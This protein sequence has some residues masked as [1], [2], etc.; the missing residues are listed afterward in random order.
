M[1][2]N[3]VWATDG[4]PYQVP[5]GNPLRDPV[6]RLWHRRRRRH[7]LPVNSVPGQR[8]HSWGVRDWW[9]MDWMWSA[10]HLEDG[11]H[12]HGVNIGYRAF[13]RSVSV[14]SRI[15]TASSPSWKRW[16]AREAFGANGLPVNTTLS[17]D[18]GELTAD[19]EVRGQ[20]PVRLT[21]PDGRVSE[22]PRAWVSVTTAD[23]RTGVGWMEWNRNL[24]QHRRERGLPRPI[25]V[26]GVSGSGK[27]TVGSALA[28][29]LRV[30]FVDADGSAPAR[31]HRQDERR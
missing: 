30:P 19:V 21:A 22:F 1:T 31:Q 28:Q 18:P 6:H 5:G 7:Q 2:M 25:V 24:A 12:L 10:V 14:T 4:T 8:D 26:M 29:R 23:G 27:S 9:S 20:A 17:L 3:L 13:P 16:T 15:P 11:T